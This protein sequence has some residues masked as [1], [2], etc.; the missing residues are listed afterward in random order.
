MN[1]SSLTNAVGSVKKAANRVAHRESALEKNLREATSNQNWGCPN[2]L[3]HD[4]ARA[5]HDYTDCQAIMTEIWTALQEKGKMWRR[6]LKALTLLEFLVKNGSERI[7]DEIRRDQ[8]KVRPLMDFSF[9]EDGKDKGAA[10]R[11]KAK[12]IVELVSDMEMLRSERDKA[13]QHRD[14]FI[15]MSSMDSSG[16]RYGGYGGGGGGGGG[17]FT[18]PLEV[19]QSQVT[20]FE[21]SCAKYTKPDSVSTMASQPSGRSSSIAS[22]S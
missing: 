4:I 7:I 19:G 9:S 21:V 3:L 16:D 20:S 10:V 14:K 18:L 22:R 1:L 8:Y 6:V 13:R 11:E 2:S 12:A 17:L 15:G 5:S